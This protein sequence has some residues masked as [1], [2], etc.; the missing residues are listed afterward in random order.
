MIKRLFDMLA[1]ATA[2]LVLSPVLLGV[3]SLV[4]IK[5]GRPVFF[6]QLRPG[7][8]EQPF[9][10][11]K[12]RTMLDSSD[13]QGQALDDAQRLTPFGRWLRSTSLDELPELWNVLKGELSL[14]GPRPLIKIGRASCRERGGQYV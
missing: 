2:L 14:V 6:R 12:F 8:H 1:A 3:A 11:L 13:A 4:A 10:M 5:M 7:L 9:L